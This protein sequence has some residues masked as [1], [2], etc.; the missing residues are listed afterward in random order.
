MITKH[1]RAVPAV[2]EALSETIWAGI[3]R[4]LIGSVR[5]AREWGDLNFQSISYQWLVVSGARA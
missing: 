4:M 5:R 3:Y 2:S 1:C